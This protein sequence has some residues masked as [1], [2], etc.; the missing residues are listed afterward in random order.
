M[1]FEKHEIII[2]NQKYSA[3]VTIPEQTDIDDIIL[4]YE[5]WSELSEL[6]T[7]YR[8][9]RVNIPEFT[10]LLFCL[11]NNCWRFN[12]V[13]GFKNS[14]T[15]FDCYNPKTYKT[16][17][18]KSASIGKDL[19][20]FGPKSTWDELY[21]MDFYCDEEYNGS[22]EIYYIPDKYIYKQ[23]VN[24]NQTM[25]DQQTQNRRPRFSIKDKI[26][27]PNQLKPIAKY[28]IYEL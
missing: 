21:F 16:I 19:T 11:V 20:S 4:M 13:K 23:S 6:L 26:I 25:E 18:I 9:R 15:S 22:F 3:E 8:C 27:T 12:N 14:H 10:E 17:Q 1:K 2:E 5:L 7:N 28:N 24:K